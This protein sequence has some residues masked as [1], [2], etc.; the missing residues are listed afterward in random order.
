VSPGKKQYFEQRERVGLHT[1][2]RNPMLLMLGFTALMVV[3]MPKLMDNMD[4]E[5]KAKLQEQMGA[6]QDPASF[7]KHMFGLPADGEDGDAPQVTD[8]R[9]ATDAAK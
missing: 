6:A 3:V 5:E 7:L 2:I 8:G 1:V 4:P 9:R